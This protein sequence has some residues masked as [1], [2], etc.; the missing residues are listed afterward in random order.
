[1]KD[2][3][4]W[5]GFTVKGSH[6]LN[7]KFEAS[8]SGVTR[9]I[10]SLE[11]ETCENLRQRS[12]QTN[13]D[14]NHTCLTNW[15]QAVPSAGSPCCSPSMLTHSCSE[16]ET[17]Q[18]PRVLRGYWLIQIFTVNKCWN[19]DQFS[20]LMLPGLRFSS[21]YISPPLLHLPLF[22][23]FKLL[24][25]GVQTKKLMFIVAITSNFI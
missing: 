10:V 17:A 11:R 14:G 6:I 25:K 23:F 13:L 3:F 9:F 8:S 15:T 2:Y 24:D 7:T 1:M 5:Q 22:F 16:R 12:C 21:P 19:Q 20:H 18:K 4:L